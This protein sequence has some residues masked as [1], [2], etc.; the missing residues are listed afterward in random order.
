MQETTTEQ[1]EEKNFKW[2][3]YFADSPTNQCGKLHNMYNFLEKY[4]WPKL[5]PI[6]GTNFRMRKPKKINFPRRNSYHRTTP[7]KITSPREV[8]SAWEKFQSRLE[9]PKS[10]SEQWNDTSCL[11]ME[12]DIKEI[13][14]L[15][16]FMI[17]LMRPK[18]LSY[19]TT[20]E[21]ITSPR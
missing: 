10:R 20:P 9:R 5:V 1:L 15:S 13:S 18:E 11:W 14:V 21:K 16:K 19:T 8:Q 7:Q 3:D 17:H 4:R 12:F 2:W 6:T